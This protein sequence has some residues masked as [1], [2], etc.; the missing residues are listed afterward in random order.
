LFDTWLPNFKRS[1]D[2]VETFGFGASRR[3]HQTILTNAVSFPFKYDTLVPSIAIGVDLG[4]FDA[5][6]IPSL[7]LSI[8]DHWRLRFEADIFLPRHVEKTNLGVT[9]SE[10][11][12][13]R[14]LGT[15]HNRDQLVARITYQF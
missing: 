4:S 6:V 1:D 15:L 7:D 13:A 5:F 14:Q 2:I 8:G 11:N 3:E 12:D 10:V 9:G